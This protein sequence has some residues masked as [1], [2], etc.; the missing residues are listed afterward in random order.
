M[1]VRIIIVDSQGSAIVDLVERKVLEGTGR[2]LTMQEA[3][4]I[5]RPYLE[6]FLAEQP[7]QNAATQT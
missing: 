7:K 1:V 3:A 5:V 4:D 6:H 2:Q